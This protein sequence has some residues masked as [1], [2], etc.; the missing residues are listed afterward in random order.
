K[1]SSVAFQSKFRPSKRFL[2]GTKQKRHWNRVSVV[3]EMDNSP[4]FVN[5]SELASSVGESFGG[6]GISIAVSS[7]S[8]ES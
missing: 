4:V 6:N 3:A 5:P 8:A 1:V 7:S 2:L